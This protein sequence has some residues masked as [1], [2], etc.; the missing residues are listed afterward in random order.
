MLKSIRD[1]VADPNEIVELYAGGGLLLYSFVFLVLAVITVYLFFAEQGVLI[2]IL[3]LSWFSLYNLYRFARHSPKSPFYLGPILILTPIEIIQRKT[4]ST[5]GWSVRWDEIESI[6]RVD[7]ANGGH[8]LG[9]RW[10]SMAAW[11][12]PLPLQGAG[13]NISSS[14]FELAMLQRFNAYRT[15]KN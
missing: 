2:I 13:F 5:E 3:C 6:V 4:L 11:E 7:D 1:R 14:Q 9:V 15:N 10:K 8:W 12:Q